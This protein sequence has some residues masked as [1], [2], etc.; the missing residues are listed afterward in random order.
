[1]EA[2]EDRTIGY[3]IT[4]IMENEVEGDVWGAATTV[5]EDIPIHMLPSTCP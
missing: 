5:T 4:V 1:M 3:R 2:P